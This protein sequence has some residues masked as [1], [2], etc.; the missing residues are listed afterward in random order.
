MGDRRMLAVA[1]AGV[2]CVAV[3]AVMITSA[4]RSAAVTVPLSVGPG[5]MLVFNRVNVTAHQGH[6]EVP[7]AIPQL[8]DGQGQR[9]LAREDRDD[10]LTVTAVTQPCNARPP[11][12][13]V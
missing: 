12:I 7:G 6:V 5:G 11:S 13:G 2:C 1:I 4:A 9:L 10:Q 3:G 8:S